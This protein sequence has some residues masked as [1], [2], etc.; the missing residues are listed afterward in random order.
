VFKPQAAQESRYSG[1]REY[2]ENPEALDQ[3]IS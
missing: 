3:P 1:N 2:R